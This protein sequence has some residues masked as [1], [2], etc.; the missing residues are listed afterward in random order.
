MAIQHAAH[1]LTRGI[2]A[3]SRTRI[4]A[5]RPDGMVTEHPSPDTNCTSEHC[6]RLQKFYKGFGLCG[7]RMQLVACD[8]EKWPTVDK[9]RDGDNGEVK[10]ALGIGENEL[11]ALKDALRKVT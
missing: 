9:L 2:W 10:A 4:D 1:G 8:D 11:K 7:Q 3:A 5:K 6:L